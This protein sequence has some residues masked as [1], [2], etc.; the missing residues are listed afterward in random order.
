MLLG[1]NLTII[2][3]LLVICLLLLYFYKKKILIFENNKG[4]NFHLFIKDLRIHMSQHHPK[5]N[6][7]FSIIGKTENEH[8]LQFRE[9]IIVENIVKQFIDYEYKKET[10]QSVEKEKLWTNYIEKSNSNS[11]YPNDWIQRKEVAWKRDNKSCNRCGEPLTLD[12][13][14]SIF[15]K[16][17]KNGGGYNLENIITLCSD[18]NK[19][20][21]STNNEHT[22]S[23]LTLSDKLMFFVKSQ[24]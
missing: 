4:D 2:F 1:I 5:I 24:D 6:I 19:I 12:H 21:N 23:V 16:D 14:F 20:V 17:I 7:D 18:C 3:I 9:T 13:A 22:N 8:H 10:Q 11:K 15:V